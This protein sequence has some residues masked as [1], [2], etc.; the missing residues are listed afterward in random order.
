MVIFVELD[1]YFS[2]NTCEKI[3]RVDPEG[4]DTNCKKLPQSSKDITKMTQML[5]REL[6][7][8]NSKEENLKKLIDCMNQFLTE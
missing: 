1:N 4:H 6:E 7:L 5:R 2:M 8:S 3:A